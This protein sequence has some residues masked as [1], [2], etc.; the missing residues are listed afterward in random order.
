[1]NITVRTKCKSG[2][3]TYHPEWSE[4]LPWVCYIDGEAMV[5]KLTLEDCRKWFKSKNMKLDTNEKGV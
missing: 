2:R 3:A 5:H 4:V 1:M